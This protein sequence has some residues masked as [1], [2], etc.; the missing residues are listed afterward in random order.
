[1]RI[2]AVDLTRHGAVMSADSQPVEILGGK[3][4]ID[5]SAAQWK[6]NPIVQRAGRRI[7]RARRELHEEALAWRS[8][9]ADDPDPFS[10]AVVTNFSWHWHRDAPTTAAEHFLVLPLYPAVYLPD[11]ERTRIW[12][13]VEQYATVPED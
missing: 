8:A 2:L 9:S 5:S 11:A 6:R 1:M 10:A 3:N 4:R 13:A 12:S 7:R